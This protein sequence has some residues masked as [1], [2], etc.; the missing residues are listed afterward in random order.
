MPNPYLPAWEYIPDGEPRVFGDR[1]YVYGSHDNAGQDMFCDYVL[2][3]WSAPVSD[4][5]HWVCHG[6]CFHVAP[7]RDHPS[8][9]DWTGPEHRL[10][11]PDVVE[12]DG[13]Y[14]LFAYILNSVGC[15][16]VADRPEGPFALLSRYR[17]SI[18]NERCGNGWFVDPGVLVDDDGRVYMGCG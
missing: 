7:D 17:Y 18:P 9:T 3:V 16:A 11:A 13:K 8:D 15:V 6:D 10:F 1:V 12:K 14:Y 5:N 4:L 2:K